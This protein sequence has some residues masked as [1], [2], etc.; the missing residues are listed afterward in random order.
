MSNQWAEALQAN[1]L[2]DKVCDQA[3]TPVVANDLADKSQLVDLTSLSI[4]DF[5][6]TDAAAFLQGQFCNDLTKVSVTRAQITGYCTPK[7]RLLALPVI[8]GIADGYRLLVPASIKDGFLKRL[9]MFI[10]RS[11][12]VVTERTDWACLGLISDAAGHTGEAGQQLG[13]L[14]PS[15][16]DVATSEAQQ[17]ICWPSGSDSPSAVRYL[18]MASINDQIALCKN[19]G[20]ALQASNAVWRLADIGAGMPSV[21][22]ATQ[23]SFVPQMMNLQLIDGLSF[24]K[25]CYPGQEIVAR[26][27]YLGKLKRHMRRFSVSPDASGKVA[28]PLAGA[29]LQAGEDVDAG[30]VIDAVLAADGRAQLLAVIKVSAAATAFSID[31]QP[32]QPLELPYELPSQQAEAA[33][34]A[35]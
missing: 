25:G 1:G 23:E 30:V 22:T 19:S 2:S 27:Q 26:M 4:I 18:V 32:L 33:T 15:A 21:T 20:I 34:G 16:M 12:V 13:A 35:G 14:P 6:G 8:V 9:T 31:G 11:K 29:S 7:G 24:T 3:V 17:L 10:M 28:V 5:T